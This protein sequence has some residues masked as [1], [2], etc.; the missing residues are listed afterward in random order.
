MVECMKC[1]NHLK[2]IGRERKNGINTFKD[3]DTRK[4]CKKC[5]KCLKGEQENYLFNY[6]SNPELQLK[7]I[8]D[9][10]KKWNLRKL[11]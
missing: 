3:W 5:F 1:K 8:K 7:L 11:L 10:K 4:F 2:K 6:N 9:F